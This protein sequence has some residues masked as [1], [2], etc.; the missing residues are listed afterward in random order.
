VNR[1]QDGFRITPLSQW[2]KPSVAPP[3]FVS[4][5]AVDMKTPPL[6]QVNDMTGD[7][8][9][10]YA[11]ELMK[12]HKP[13]ATDWSVVARMKRLGIVPGRSFDFAGADPVV[14]QALVE[15]PA[16]GLK[17]LQASAPNLA[18]VVNGWQMLT[19]TMGVYGNSYLKRA[20]VTMVGLGAL[21]VL[22]L[23]VAQLPPLLVLGPVILHL[24]AS[25][26]GTVTIALFTAWS[27]IVT[28]S[29]AVLKPLLLG[30]GT[31]TPRP[32]ILIGAI[33]RLLLHGLIGLFVGAVVFSTGYRLF[34]RWM[35]QGADTQPGPAAEAAPS[36]GSPSG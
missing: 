25:D 19:E 20:W 15:A 22:I 26:A 13:H 16:E 8:Y 14:R 1:F 7:K 18:R 33:G 35:G 4:D 24:V 28:A 12:L 9:F 11:A 32:V 5:P 2:G 27:V 21:P 36:P 30:R 3:A 10:S 6:N 31:G 17:Q 34:G 23:A 29:D